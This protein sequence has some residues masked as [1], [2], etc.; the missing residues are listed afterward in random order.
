MSVYTMG[1]PNSGSEKAF[2]KSFSSLRDSLNFH[3]KKI[4]NILNRALAKP[5]RSNVYWNG[6]RSDLDREYAALF[7]LYDEWSKKNIPIMYRGALIAVE[8]QISQMANVTAKA[9]KTVSQLMTGQAAQ[10]ITQALYRDSMASWLTGLTNGKSNMYRLTR[11]TQQAVVQ[12]WLIDKTA[13]QAIESGD[14]RN[15]SN[16]LARNSSQY[17]NLLNAHNNERYI[18]AGSKKYRPEYYAEMVSR[19]KFHEAQSS[20]SLAQAVNYKTDLMVVSSHNTTTE[21]C[22]KF[23]GKIFSISGND[24]RFPPLTEMS[25]YHPNCLHLMFPQFES[26][27]EASGTLAGFSDFSKGKAAKPPH[28]TGFIPVSEREVI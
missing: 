28:P 24:K 20:A 10:Q 23:E 3:T 12:E 18:Q 16:I 26:A 9:S 7:K 11:M 22:L 17:A 8:K 14:I 1:G 4:N 5:S 19:V 15:F 6:V 25:P 21:I 2:R 13:A 27:L